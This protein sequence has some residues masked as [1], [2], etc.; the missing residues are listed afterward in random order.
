ARLHVREAERIAGDS[1]ARLL[2]ATPSLAHGL[3]PLEH[4]VE[5]LSSI[6]STRSSEYTAL[7]EQGAT[8]RPVDTV[9]ADRAWLFYTSG[10]TGRPKGAVLSHRN[11]LFMSHCYY[12]D[13]DMLDERDTNLHAGPLS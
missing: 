6:I 11:L 3:A 9:P 5:S 10:T 13:I 4:S 7:L 1:G 12:A 2:V 8:M